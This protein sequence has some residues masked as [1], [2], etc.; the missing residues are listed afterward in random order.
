MP[1]RSSD[2]G[3]DQKAIR[4]PG[5]RAKRHNAFNLNASRSACTRVMQGGSTVCCERGQPK[6]TGH[7]ALP[8]SPPLRGTGKVT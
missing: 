6:Y 8:P 1:T 4:S 5:R 7:T 2:P 3:L